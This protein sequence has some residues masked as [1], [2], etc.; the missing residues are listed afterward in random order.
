[1]A[2]S[3]IYIDAADG[4]KRVMNNKSL[5]IRLLT[6]FKSEP[7]LEDLIAAFNAQDIEKARASAH[8][9]K[10]TAANLSLVE[11]QK[12]A[13]FVEDQIKNTVFDAEALATLTACYTETLT[14]I[15][16]AIEQYGE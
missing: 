5:Y 16:K 2:D 15:D 6:K 7:Y 8:T 11:L 9:I 4:L 1:M 12:R 10:G 13:L 14:E 3:I